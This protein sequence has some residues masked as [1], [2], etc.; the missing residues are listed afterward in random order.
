MPTTQKEKPFEMEGFYYPASKSAE[1]IEIQKK[2]E[3]YIVQLISFGSAEY[4]G[5]VQFVNEDKT[6]F[7]AAEQ[8][9]EAA[10]L[11]T[12]EKSSKAIQVRKYN[13]MDDEYEVIEY[14]QKAQR[15][16]YKNYEDQVALF[17]AELYKSDVGSLDADQRRFRYAVYD[18]NGDGKQEYIV[19][20]LNGDYCGSGGCTFW[21]LDHNRKIVSKTTVA[22]FPF[23]I[24]ESKSNGWHD[25]AL[26]SDR[27][28]RHLKYNNQYPANAST[29]EKYIGGEGKEVLGTI[30]KGI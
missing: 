9:G 20:I 16:D 23:F 6:Q 24:L 3:G 21:V 30:F 28:L 27:K 5:E 12:L 4:L 10:P 29:Q 14:K 11:Y 2:G 25:L 1:A 13:A 22:D 18:L 26:P 7:R 8:Q 17:V 19:T 15:I